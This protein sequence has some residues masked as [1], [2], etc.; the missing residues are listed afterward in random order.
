MLRKLALLIPALALFLAACGDGGTS[1]T[2]NST[3]ANEEPAA[4]ADDGSGAEDAN[5]DA[6][7][8]DG[9]GAGSPFLASLNPID[10]L[11]AMEA[12]AAGPVNPELA[13]FLL[14]TS[15]FPSGFVA[16]GDFGS[17]ITTEYGDI[18]FAANMFTNG[19][20]ESEDLADMGTLAL[21]GAMALPPEAIEE[22]QQAGD[23]SQAD[24]DAIE[25]Q[26]GELA[27]FAQLELLDASD[28]GDGGFGLRMTMDFAAIFGG[29]G[30]PA[31]DAEQAA[32]AMEMYVF[33]RGDHAFMVMTAWQ[34]NQPPA[35]DA[36]ELAEVMAAKA[37]V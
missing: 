2:S 31:E 28:L 37:G 12:P 1:T 35:A 10:L 6:V 34:D 5:G 23:I 7:A 9:S 3:G 14:D 33:L 36:R 11:G 17:R 21:S 20:F 29:L 8:G 27:G 24:L 22:F 26:M 32:L 30:A 4:V 16:V 13:A 18:A 25:S 19:D 15:D